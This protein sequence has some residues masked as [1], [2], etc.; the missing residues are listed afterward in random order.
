[1]SLNNQDEKTLKECA[2]IFRERNYHKKSVAI[3]N[4]AKIKYEQI[5]VYIIKH[6]NVIYLS[7]L[8]IKNYLFKVH[9]VSNTNIINGLTDYYYN[10]AVLNN[11]KIKI[12]I[13]NNDSLIQQDSFHLDFLLEMSRYYNLIIQDFL[14]FILNCNIS[15]QDKIYHYIFTVPKTKSL[16]KKNEPVDKIS[17]KAGIKELIFNNKLGLI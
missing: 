17:I 5:Q 7:C 1:M 2:E 11:N 9:K 14:I 4:D 12:V 3:F 16:Y 10:N 15:I 13:N 6:E 8:T